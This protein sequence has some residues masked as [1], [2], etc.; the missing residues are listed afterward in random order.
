MADIILTIDKEKQNF[1]VGY[2]SSVIVSF[3][4][5]SVCTEEYAFLCKT[6]FF[7]NSA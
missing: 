5:N 1:S 3:I 4:I 2:R 7:E 6:Y